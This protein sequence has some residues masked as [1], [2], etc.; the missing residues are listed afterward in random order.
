M[1]GYRFQRKLIKVEDAQQAVLHHV[2]LQERE[3]V[4]L[5]ESFGRRLAESVCASHPVPHFRRSGVDGY[6]V[7]AED[8]YQASPENAVT[9]EVTETIPCGVIPVSGVERGQAARIMTGAVVPSGADAVIMLEMTE[10]SAREVCIRKRMDKGENITP[11]G[12]EVQEDE[13]LLQLGQTIGPGEAA[14]L[15]AFGYE[16]VWVFRKPRVAIFST[17]SELLEVGR[18]LE[19]GKIRNSNSYM[20][21]C[22]VQEAGGVPLIMPILPDDPECVEAALLKIMEQVDFIITTGGVSV[23]DKDVLVDLFERWDGRLL[24]NKVAMRPGSP[25]SVGLWRDRLLFALSGNPGASYVGF[26]LFVRP[27]MRGLLGYSAMIHNEITGSLQTDYSKGSAYPRYVRGTV[28][29]NNSSVFVKPAGKD[30]SSNMVSIKDADC[31]ICIPAG[32]RGA[33]K[34]ETVR[35]ILLKEPDL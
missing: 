30:K 17:G 1:S 26:E 19:H 8:S 25:T 14:L 13:L 6:A 22:Q 18:P 16:R 4:L 32:G 12:H 9:L 21:A 35:V 15:A 24:F 5:E 2:R 34:G 3:E 23:G 29:V 20:L 11:I 27:Y 28:S 31:L 33:A 7:R 10:A